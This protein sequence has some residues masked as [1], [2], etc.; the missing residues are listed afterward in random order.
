MR[1][2]KPEIVQDGDE[3][4]VSAR[5]SVDSA[6]TKLPGE[7][8]FR[9]PVN[10]QV[11]LSSDLN[12][13]AVALL[14]LAMT[15]AEDL[16]LEG[17]IS[18]RLLWGMME[19]QR[20]QCAWKPTN[21]RPVGIRPDRLQE[22]RPG[23]SG[24]GVGCSFSAG[25]DSFH[26]LWNHLPQNEPLQQYRI[27]TC[28]MINGFDADSDLENRGHFSTIQRTV[29][30]VVRS[31]GIDL[32]VCRTNYMRFSD[33]GILKQS[34]GAMV[35]VPA[36]VLGQLFSRF[37][38]P[39][40]YRFDEF[41][42]DGSHPI[43]DHLIGT[44]SMETVHDSSYLNRPAKTEVIAGWDATHSTLRVCA[45][46]TGY[47]EDIGSIQNCG[48]CEKCVRTMKTL[49]ILQRRDDFT[50]FAR[51]AGHAGVWKCYF[52]HK[53]ARIHALEV[54]SAAWKARKFGIW[55]DYLI[56]IVISFVIK[57]P[58]ELIQLVH[59]FLEERSVFYATQVR[60]LFPRL[61]RRAHW[62]R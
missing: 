50:T 49:E 43:L 5:V 40:S 34:F 35:T 41:F 6:R 24:S 29:E 51:K 4:C 7:L 48:R 36:L 20:I 46:A 18:P 17:A 1:V 56:A 12:G 55:A 22:A 39:S 31:L 30:P 52:G 16:I 54:M 3:V 57:G 59:L 27:T 38:V 60:R 61:R 2:F 13:F 25:V 26:T 37:Y 47:R 10:C 11:H 33:P 58:R 62:I 23:P 15:L 9:F 14:P 28:L 19:Y 45:N 42:R 8:W 53:G 44:E 32:V 21:F